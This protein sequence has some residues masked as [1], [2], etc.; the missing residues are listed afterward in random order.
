M[1]RPGTS[2]IF[3]LA[4]VFTDRAFLCVSSEVLASQQNGCHRLQK[5][6]IFTWIA[7]LC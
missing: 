1:N 2:L 6:C 5:S 4:Q 7:H 3:F